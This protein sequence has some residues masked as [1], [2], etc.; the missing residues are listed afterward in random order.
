MNKSNWIR[1]RVTD[2]EKSVIYE[3]AKYFEMKVSD[4]VRFVSMNTKEIKKEEIAIN[5]EI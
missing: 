1:V 3:R 2:E 4:Y 5:R